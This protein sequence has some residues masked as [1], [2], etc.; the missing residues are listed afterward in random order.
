MTGPPVRPEFQTAP[1][2]KRAN[3]DGIPVRLYDGTLVAHVNEELADRLLENAAAE[4]FRRGPR[5]YLRLRQGISIPRAEQGWD[6]IEFLRWWHG[7]KRAA[8]YVEHNDRQSE[9]LRYRPPSPVPE[10]LRRA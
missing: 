2:T 8:A 3:P 10:R 9:C 4:A 5:R 6:V 7:D 1:T